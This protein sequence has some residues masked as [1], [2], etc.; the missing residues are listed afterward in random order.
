M[1]QK[2]LFLINREW[3]SPALDRLMAIMS[4][5]TFWA[6]PLALI[7]AASCW[8][9]GFRARTFV[10]L[11][12]LT[13][14]LTDGVV[15]RTLK[16]TVGRARPSQSEVGV[17]TVNLASP[18]WR[19]VFAPVKEKLSTGD[20]RGQR[21]GS[22]PSNHA[23]NT[24]G[25]AL[26]AALLWRRWGWL[27][28]LPALCVAY[29]RVYVGSHWP[30]DALA[31]VCIGCATAFLVLTLAEFVWRRWGQRLAPR[32]AAQHPSLFMATPA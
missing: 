13:F 7:V 12:L 3:T 11:A 26:I 10:I 27:A 24:A 31:G 22:F 16:K 28:F 2:L 1:D 18:A 6:V 14:G 20:E 4:S 25:I 15:G 29:S 8:W 9:G 32:V 30:T 21:G 5:V 19:G 17:R 23:A